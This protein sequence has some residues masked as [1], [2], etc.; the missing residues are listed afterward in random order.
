ME[1]IFCDIVQRKAASY[2]IYEDEDFIGILDKFPIS[3]GHSLV[4]PKKHIERVHDL[5]L[6]D[7]C[8]LYARVYALNRIITSKV[9]AS[10]SHVSINDGPAANQLVPHVHVHIIPRNENDNAG[11]TS[12]KLVRPE[13]MEDLRKKLETKKLELSF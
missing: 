9:N 5:S 13:D 1:C 4:I 6:R 12:R 11:F 8:A 3:I 10:A 2:I 7:F